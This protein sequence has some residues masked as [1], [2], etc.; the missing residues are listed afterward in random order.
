MKLRL[1]KFVLGMAIAAGSLAVVGCGGGDDPL[2]TAASN[3]VQTVSAATAPASKTLVASI[4]GTSGVS[5]AIPTAVTVGGATIAAGST[6]T[7]APTTSTSAGAIGTFTLA[8]TGKSVTGE[9]EGGSCKF[10]VKTISPN[11]HPDGW[12]VGQ[13]YAITPCNLTLPTKGTTAGTATLTPTL[14]LGSTV[15]TATKTVAVTVSSDGKLQVNG[16][17]IDATVTLSTGGN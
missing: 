8:S 2:P 14:A 1:N 12:V 7:L 3:A 16:T 13:S 9:V 6:L 10:V 5:F 17:T 15:V 4:A 11:P